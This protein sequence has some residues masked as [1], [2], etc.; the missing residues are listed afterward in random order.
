M[1]TFHLSDAPVIFLGLWG[2]GV[3]VGGDVFFFF[4]YLFFN[5]YY[6]FIYLLLFEKKI[7]HCLYI[8]LF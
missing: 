8:A 7:Q 4:I 2:L 5:F 3:C 6:Y 1:V